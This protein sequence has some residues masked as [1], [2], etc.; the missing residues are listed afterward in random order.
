MVIELGGACVRKQKNASKWTR[1]TGLARFGETQPG[2]CLELIIFS[3]AISPARPHLNQSGIL[4]GKSYLPSNV[5]AITLR[6]PHYGIWVDLLRAPFYFFIF[7]LLFFFFFFLFPFSFF[8]LFFSCFCGFL[9]FFI[10]VKMFFTL[11]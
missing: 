2:G 4:A 10:I 11:G 9:F 5:E 1:S 8:L 7:L 3:I 6:D